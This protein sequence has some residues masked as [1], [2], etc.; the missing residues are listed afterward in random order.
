MKVT[1][2]TV[3][4]LKEDVHSFGHINLSFQKNDMCPFGSPGDEQNK[5]VVTTPSLCL[6]FAK[7][8]IVEDDVCSCFILIEM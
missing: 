5:V 1:S 6:G 2:S 3:V 8:I 4:S 7:C